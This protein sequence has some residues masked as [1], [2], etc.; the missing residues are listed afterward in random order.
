MRAIFASALL[1]LFLLVATSG[2]TTS[3]ACTVAGWTSGPAVSKI[4]SRPVRA[5]GLEPE[6][7][8]KGFSLGLNCFVV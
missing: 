4:P 6:P 2:A 7:G 1:A 3:A 8:A 5:G